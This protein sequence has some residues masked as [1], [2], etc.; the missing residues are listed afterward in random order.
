MDNN[1]VIESNALSISSPKKKSSDF[2][3][4]KVFLVDIFEK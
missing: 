4:L 3:S 2:N 1:E